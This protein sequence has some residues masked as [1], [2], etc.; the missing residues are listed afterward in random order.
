MRSIQISTRECLLWIALVVA[1]GGMLFALLCGHDAPQDQVAAV[2]AG[3]PPTQAPVPGAVPR[4]TRQCREWAELNNVAADMLSPEV[5][6]TIPASFNPV[7]KESGFEMPFAPDTPARESATLADDNPAALCAALIEALVSGRGSELS[8]IRTRLV[9][10]GAM[11]VPAVSALLRSGAEAVEVEAVRLLV[12]IGNA[13]GLALAVGRVLTVPR[14]APAYSLYL[15]AFADHGSSAVADWL[16]D[17]L[18]NAQYAETRERTLDLLYVMRGPAAV[19][20]LERAALTPADNMHAQDAIDSLAMRHDPADTAS[21][22]VLLAS[23]DAAI[24]EAAAY[25][26]ANVG[27]GEACETLADATESGTHPS[28]AFALASVSSSYAQETLLVL[29]T[30]SSRSVTVRTSAI[31]SLSGHSGQRVQTVLAN[32]MPQE[33]SV[34]LAA[35]MQTTLET[36]NNNAVEINDSP[37]AEGVKGELWY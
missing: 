1:I 21:L 7:D 17:T 23:E 26:L 37:P 13:E 6:A 3:Q 9:A 25:G 19:A 33:Q 12:Q 15:A 30:D 20:A 10:L 28:Y 34:P 35:E 4:V 18:G 36:I 27:S 16:A 24:S 14:E 29:A 32:A 5:V 31:Q 2:S 11:A 22:A 8:A